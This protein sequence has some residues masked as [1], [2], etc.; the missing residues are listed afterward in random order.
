MRCVRQK[1]I[2]NLAQNSVYVIDNAAYH[3]V[4]SEK[5]PTS[6]SRKEDMENLLLKN[7]IPFSGDLLKTEFYALIKQH[8]P[9]HRRYILDDFLRA[10]GHTVLRLPPYHP[11]LNAIA[12]I[13]GDVEQ[14]VGQRDVTFNLYGMWQMCEQH[15]AE[16]SDMEW[17]AVCRRVQ[18][19]EEQYVRTEGLM[20]PQV[21]RLMFIVSGSNNSGDNSSSYSESDST[22]DVVSSS[23]DTDDALHWTVSRNSN[24]LL[25]G[26]IRDFTL[27]PQFIYLFISHST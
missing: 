20:E 4:L 15:F 25:V 19:V 1:L 12:N 10:Q 7:Q 3:N 24:N 9:R 17:V 5:Y 27:P 14:W 23:S 18:N 26:N 6:S 8:K 21:E 22:L 2:P 16:I 13:C 11:E